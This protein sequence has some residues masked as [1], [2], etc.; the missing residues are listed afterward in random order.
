MYFSSLPPSQHW[1]LILL[2][3][4]H[5]TLLS[6]SPLEYIVPPLATPGHTDRAQQF[7]MSAHIYEKCQQEAG[8]GFGKE[9]KY[10]FSSQ[11][12]VLHVLGAFLKYSPDE[13][14][15]GTWPSP[16]PPQKALCTTE[17]LI[18]QIPF[19]GLG[20]GPVSRESL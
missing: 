16:A 2:Q 8:W 20:R 9:N 7:A 19:M 4:A 10:C 12:W 3:T 1:P 17:P 13:E 6:P 5:P 15:A 11:H 14:M 18:P